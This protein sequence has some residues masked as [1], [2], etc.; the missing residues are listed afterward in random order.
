MIAAETQHVATS[1]DLLDVVEVRVTPPDAVCDV[2]DSQSVRPA[3]LP[4]DHLGSGRPVH[5][6]P[7]DVRLAAPVCPEGVT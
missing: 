5:A 4:G 3:Q 7:P 1:G 6:D 2:V